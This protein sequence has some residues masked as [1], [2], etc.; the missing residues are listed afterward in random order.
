MKRQPFTSYILEKN[1]LPREKYRL[2][3]GIG[4][5][6]IKNIVNEAVLIANE[7]FRSGVSTNVFKLNGKAVYS[8][9]CLKEKI[10]LRHCASNLN[11]ALG[12]NLKQRNTIID[13]VKC[14]LKEGS[15]FR[16]YRLDI[17]SFF[18]SIDTSVL[19]KKIE[20]NIKISRHTRNL[21]EWYLK[22]CKL[23]LNNLG[24]PRGLEI[25]P[26]LSEIY[27][28][29][30]DRIMKECHHNLYYSR[31]VDDIIIITKGNESESSYLDFINNS[32]PYGLNLNTLK[33]K[34]NISPIIDSRKQG[35]QPNGTE[36]H[37]FDFLGYEIKII[38]SHVPKAGK[39][40]YKA[41]YRDV[42]VNFSKKRLKKF[43]TRISRAFY[44]YNKTS[45]F[46]MLTDRLKF[47]TSNRGIKRQTKGQ[48]VIMKKNISTGIFYSNSK[49]DSDSPHLKELDDFIFFCI[50]NTNARINKGR[51][52]P[53]TP[54][55]IRTL[56][57]NSF[58]SGFK[59]RTHISFNFNKCVE[60]TKIWS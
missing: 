35:Q 51:I 57:K 29:D 54:T 10:I 45:D 47:L 17:R 15:K 52:T 58:S 28:I 31:F 24:L 3:N 6:S 22:A 60:I 41:V 56:L 48:N 49:L 34:K 12:L 18:E 20:G 4:I 59:K 5:N 33:H 40:G 39:N 23:K 50:K 53:L 25:S 38:D 1:L 46:T 16:V 7:N 8:T 43:K 32:L 13:E 14:Y 27:L 42:K 21:V 44:S 30:F 9:N 11:Q 19:I 36:L 26:I 2:R 55:Q 37:S